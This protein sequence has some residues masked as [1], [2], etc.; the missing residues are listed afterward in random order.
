MA[1]KIH[2]VPLVLALLL[3]ALL[4][5]CGETEPAPSSGGEGAPEDALV[6][7]FYPAWSP[8]EIYHAGDIVNSRALRI[9]APCGGPRAASPWKT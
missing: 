8:D 5:A 7:T 1:V 3:A 2:T 6:D 4:C 9:S